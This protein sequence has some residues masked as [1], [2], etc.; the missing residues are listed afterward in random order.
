V[1]AISLWDSKESAD[2]YN[3]N[4]YPQVLKTLD[5]VIDGVPKVRTSECCLLHLS[6]D[7]YGCSLINRQALANEGGQPALSVFTFG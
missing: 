4:T 5:R 7:R 6:Q 3:S 1:I 2:A